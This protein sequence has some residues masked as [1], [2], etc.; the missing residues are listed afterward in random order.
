[1]KLLNRKQ[2]ISL[3]KAVGHLRTVVIQG[4]NG[5]G[6]TSIFHE[7]CRDPMFANHIKTNPVDC[8][9][10][11]DGSVWMP[12]VDREQG[13]SRELPNERFG[14]SK[15]NQKGV[16]GSRP[17]LVFLDEILKTRQYIKDMIAPMIYDRRNGSYH[18]VEGSVI[19]CATNLAM[20]GLGDVIQPHL[21]SRLITVTMAKPTCDEWVQHATDFGMAAEVIACADEHPMWFDS[22]LDYMPNGKHHGKVMSKDNAVPFNPNEAQDGYVSPRTLHIASDIVHNK[23]LVDTDTMQAALEGTIGA[24]AAEA[25][26][27]Y[28]RFG[29]DN[30]SFDE[31]RANPAHARVASSPVA[32]IVMA[33]K[34]VTNTQDRDDAEAA[35]EYVARLKGE[36]QNLFVNRVANTTSRLSH[37]LTVAPFQKM[38]AANKIYFSN[39]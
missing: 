1:M 12:D 29:Q 32:Q 23:D 17:V 9:Q 6:K 22:F 25:L 24:T 20:E 13:V 35:T 21:K 31:V 33:F 4:E 15:N 3:I 34:L 39:K 28:I 5:V 16:N 8:M 10:L 7:L 37:F 19:C 30:P 38:L 11:S 36:M 18:F 2:I 14:V 26:A 27:A